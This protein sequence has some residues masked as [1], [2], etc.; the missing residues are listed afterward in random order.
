MGSIFITNDKDGKK[1]ELAYNRSSLVRMEKEGFDLKKIETEPL[2]QITLLIRGA[3][4]K[5][6][7]SLSNDEIDA[8]CDDIGGMDGLVKELL[9]LYENGLMI[10]SGQDKQDA[11][12]FK[13]EKI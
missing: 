2:F 6:H 12:N 4:Y 10:L 8:I 9:S 1:Y 7:P 3:F 5:N 11:K 13:W